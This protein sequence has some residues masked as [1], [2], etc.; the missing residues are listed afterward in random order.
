MGKNNK[1]EIQKSRENMGKQHNQASFGLAIGVL[2]MIVAIMFVGVMLLKTVSIPACLIVIVT[3]ICIISKYALK[4]SF[5]ELMGIMAES[6]RNGTAGLWFFVAIG[7]IIASWMMA[8]T[9]PAIIYYGLKLIS[10]QVFLP[11]GFLLCSATALCTGTSWGT[12]GT[13]GIA[14][15]GIGQGMGIPLPITAAMIV[16]GAAF[17]DKMSPVSDTPNL[18]SMSAETEL[19]STLKAMIITMV[20]AY[21]ISMVLFTVVGLK[22]GSS[23]MNYEVIE[24]TR[25]VLAANFNLNP[26]VLLPII[27]LLVLSVKKFPALPSMAIAIVIG[28]VVAIV[29]QGQGVAACLESLNSGFVIETGSEYVDPILNR[30]GLQN[31]LWTF[32]V[33]FLAISMGGLLDKCGYL[34]AIVAGLLKKVKT[35]GSLSLI[36]LLTSFI[37]TASFSEVYLSLILN[38]T[39][40]KSEFD[41]RGLS[42]SMLARLV[43]EGALMPAPMMPWT[44]FGAFCMA[45]LGISGLEFAPYAFLN[46]LSPI[47]SLIMAY[48]GIGVIWN[49][50]K[51]KGKR[52]FDEV[53]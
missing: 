30:G 41:K 5:D 1:E 18:V 3:L 8:G 43:S 39:V 22:Y 20:P 21:I 47:V 51:N 53:K 52:R 14:L 11:A 36:V 42:R 15:V 35:V 46:Y 27:V 24:E 31:M 50:K 12:V 29:F 44:T 40:Y 13:V 48:L 25:S 7:G 32:S 19:Y 34:N 33:A 6:I 10:P 9:V 26:M 28:F 49:D 17:G 38:G 4:Y 16:S 23:S 45:T 2:A 37:A